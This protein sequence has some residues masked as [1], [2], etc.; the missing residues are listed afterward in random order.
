MPIYVRLTVAQTNHVSITPHGETYLDLDSHADTSVLGSNA[1]L[2]ELPYPERTA[3]VS[4]ADPS[5]GTITKPILS[6]AFKYTSLY[7][8]NSIILVVHQ[9][10]HINTMD[11]SLLYPMQMRE[12][13]IILDETPKCMIEN[14]TEM[15]HSMLVITDEN[16][17]HRIPFRIR[18]VSS[19]MYVSKP[20][21][22]EYELLP[23]V[24]LTSHDLEWN[25]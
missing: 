13:D 4:F 7:D 19:T 10:I 14:P 22:K 2:V 18:G 25:P 17:K 23:H 1:L 20:T 24:E 8:G 16:I 21:L 15:N 3:I 6:G 12:N 11:H 5:V 9:A